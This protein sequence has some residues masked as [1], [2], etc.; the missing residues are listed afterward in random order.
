MKLEATE[1]ANRIISESITDLKVP[2]CHRCMQH[3]GSQ[4][5]VLHVEVSPSK[6]GA[7]SLDTAGSGERGNTIMFV[8]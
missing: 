4:G 3:P 2:Q 8:Q 6:E 1:N 5:G 7:L